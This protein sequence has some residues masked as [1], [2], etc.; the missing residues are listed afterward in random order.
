M[1]WAQH[2]SNLTIHHTYR[3]SNNDTGALICSNESVERV[4]SR[5]NAFFFTTRFKFFFG[6]NLFGWRFI[7]FICVFSLFVHVVRSLLLLLLHA[8]CLF[9]FCF[10]PHFNWVLLF[11]NYGKQF[12]GHLFLFC[13]HDADAV[14]HCCGFVQLYNVLYYSSYPLCLIP[15]LVLVFWD[16]DFIFFIILNLFYCTFV[17][18]FK[19]NPK[20]FH[21]L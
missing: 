4:L 9:C 15:K 10:F 5:R 20:P 14:F 13:L 2:V 7:R 21:Y 17:F 19:I 18:F 16:E 6:E 11:Y 3:G 12:L 8:F 1:F